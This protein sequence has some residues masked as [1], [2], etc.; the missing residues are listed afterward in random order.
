MNEINPTFRESFKCLASKCTD[1]C[2]AGWEIDIDPET[3]EKYKNQKGAFGK[4]LK[5]YTEEENGE[6]RFKLKS[7][8]RCPFLNSENLC[9]IIINMGQDSLCEICALHPRF[10]SENDNFLCSGFG[11][12]CEE[13]CLLLFD[14]KYKLEYESD[15]GQTPEFLNAE[16]YLSFFNYSDNKENRLRATEIISLA[17]N[18]DPIDSKWTKY[19]KS[20]YKEREDVINIMMSPNKFPKSFGTDYSKFI[21][22][23]IFRYFP[24]CSELSDAVNGALVS[25]YIM[26]SF[27]AFTMIK[28]NGQYSF[29]DRINNAKL[30]S[31]QMEYSEENIE[32]I[33]NFDGKF[34]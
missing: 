25:A 30:F 12:C 26:L 20:L 28:N 22:Y 4:K 3:C 33:F 29:S 31:K 21:S 5:K 23:E 24:R 13:T 16:N 34:I 19:I 11:L 10:F 9:E 27:D 6:Y 14:E 32:S 7:D 8:G 17:L 1:T 15:C 2:C 18:S